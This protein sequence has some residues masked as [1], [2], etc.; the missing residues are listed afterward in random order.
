MSKV[1]AC[2]DG[3]G[4]RAEAVCDTA[5]W[6][7]LTLS[8]P[9]SL[10]HVLDKREYP[11]EKPAPL[12]GAIGLGAREALLEQLASLDEQRGKIAREQGRLMLA[13]ALERARSDGAF[14]P[15]SLQRHGDLV[16]TLQE[17]Q[18]ETRLLVLG[19]GAHGDPLGGHLEATIRA[20][21]RPIL[22]TD[23]PLVAPR[24]FLLA[25]DGSQTARK[26]LQMVADSPL[27]I[28]ASCELLMVGP[29]TFDMQQELTQ[30]EQTLVAAGFTVHAALR[31]GEADQVILA[32]LSRSHADL[33]V[34]GAY[35]H[36]RIRQLLVGST[37]TTLLR[38]SPVPLLLLR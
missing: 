15:D 1:V 33:L 20:L 24:R 34:M 30:A 9:L 25:Y 14:Q 11:T 8:A 37:T 4:E 38:Q 21:H 6:A 36:S 22:I 18:Q 35:G 10:L 28:G 29:S 2:I 19:K 5:S 17:M 27:L 13:A 12:S 23:Q 3:V 26:A 31:A 16:G 32:E 7:S